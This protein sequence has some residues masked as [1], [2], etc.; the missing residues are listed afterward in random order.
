LYLLK[1]IARAAHEQRIAL[2]IVG[3]FVRDLLLDRPG[4]DFDLVV[5]GNAINLAKSLAHI[6]G[7]R[8]TSH[9]RF[10]TA[11]WLLT[12][13]RTE[14]AKELALEW[15]DQPGPRSENTGKPALNGEELPSSIDLIT[16]RTEFYTHPTALPTVEQGSI[17]LDLHRRDFTINT[18]AL[19]LDGRHYGELHD[20]WGGLNDLRSGLV[21]VL[22]SLS[23]V[24]D[25]TRMLRAARF[26]Q[27]FNFEI[28]GRTKEL[29]LQAINLLD[30]IS[31][32]RIRHELDHIL[33]EPKVARILA[34][35]DELNLLKAIHSDLSWDNWLDEHIRNAVQ[36]EPEK[37]WQLDDTG[38]V[39]GLPLRRDLIYA[40]WLLRLPIARAEKISNRLK[41]SASLRRAVQAGCE[42]RQGLPAL[43]G[44]E[45]SQI[46]T[47]LETVP[48][49]ARYAVYLTTS[50]QDAR[51]ILEQYAHTWRKISPYTNG[52]ELQ[53]M[54]LPPGPI[55]RRILEQLRSAWLNGDV[56]SREE[57]LDLLAEILQQAQRK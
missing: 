23:F 1:T 11:K 3:G 2:Y 8:V 16:A 19:R 24:D 52:N 26:E 49:L 17:K 56:H 22:H 48:P 57:E 42:L 46:V 6:Y 54:G 44:A 25:P 39:P 50:D 34:R 30:R 36:A 53:A 29:L 38:F 4:L 37:D 14:L 33:V 45:L 5:E 47:R 40:I 9:T 27:R 35:L 43:I 12:G 55:Y 18:L 7:G 51:Q 31:G 13:I 15:Q 10:G 21:R 41:L 32:D 20:Y 28:E